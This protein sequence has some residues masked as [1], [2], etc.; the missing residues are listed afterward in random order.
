MRVALLSDIHGNL[1]AL[2]AVLTALKQEAADQIVCLGDVAIFGPQPGETLARIRALRC[3]VVMGN[4]DA[5][6]LDPQPHPLRNA[7]SPRFND[8][9][10]WGA[11]QLTADDLAFI[12]TFQPI[13]QLTLDNDIT[14]LC[15]H[16]SPRSYHDVILG[17]TPDDELRVMFSGFTATAMAGGHTHT[18]MLRRLETTTVLNPG[19]VGLPFERLP[20]SQATRNPP[21]AEFVIVEWR[22]AGLQ[23]KFC[24]TPI[25][26]AAVIKTVM[27]SAMPHA[28][29]WLQGWR[30]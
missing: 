25:N 29:W 28:E 1:L 19:S 14:L 13:V 6:A 15:Y 7:D 11:A 18:P 21:W 22:D 26:V 12:R 30:R 9:E 10:F 3:P 8:V 20:G 23:I 2:E 27:E 4:T 16:G 24:R 17:T 5:W